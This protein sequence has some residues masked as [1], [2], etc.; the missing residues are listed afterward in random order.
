MRAV[1]EQDTEL[2]D[3]LKFLRSPAS[4][5]D[6]PPTVDVVETHF[7]WVFL[8]GAFVY[9][10]KKPI[11]FHGID[12][13]TAEQRRTS[14]ELEVTMNHRLADKVYIGVVPLSL[15]GTELGF[16]FGGT[17]VDWLVKMHRLDRDRMLDRRAAAGPVATAELERLVAKLARFYRR[18][19]KA[20][21]TG[22]EYRAEIE[23]QLDWHR[24][25]LAALPIG[26]HAKPVAR[27]V[28]RQLQ[29]VEGNRETLDARIAAGRVVDAHGDLR[30]EHIYLAPDPQIIDCLEF[31]AELRRLDAA[32]D[33]SFLDLEC[34]RLGFG[35]LGTTLCA[36]YRRGCS[37]PIGPELYA[38]YRSRR[39]LARAL[40]SAWH[41]E[42][43][44]GAGEG[45]RWLDRTGWYLRE[46]TSCI[47]RAMA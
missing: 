10:L 40:V 9:K 34:D 20:P 16:G 37:D 5:P 24:K 7:S 28:A 33:L 42:S 36:L 32:E 47:E 3:K 15:C 46:A 38:F 21:W 29:F 30:P 25:Q 13:R 12:Y 41:L 39:A 17:V 45:R 11:R 19:E 18:A 14:C 43:P 2:A 8:S 31:S 1:L 22:A 35:T 4:Y 26:A 23:A 6:A 27:L 44:V